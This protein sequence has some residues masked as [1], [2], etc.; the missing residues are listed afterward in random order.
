MAKRYG[1][2]A[3]TLTSEKGLVAL[4]GSEKALHMWMSINK[5]IYDAPGKLVPSDEFEE[6]Y[7][8]IKPEDNADNAPKLKIHKD[9]QILSSNDIEDMHWRFPV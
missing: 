8:V 4:F 6:A 9:I 7:S 5:Y 3:I 1:K 2:S